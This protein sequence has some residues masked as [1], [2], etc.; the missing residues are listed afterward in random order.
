MPM[1]SGRVA[2]RRQNLAFLAAA[3]GRIIF[4]AYRQL[5]I[6]HAGGQGYEPPPP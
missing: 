6:G 2:E 5:S 1:A 3:S 4:W